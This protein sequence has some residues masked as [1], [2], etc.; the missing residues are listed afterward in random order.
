MS[1]SIQSLTGLQQNPYLMPKLC[2]ADHH[3]GQLTGGVSS[4]VAMSNEHK[5]EISLTA[6]ILFTLIS[7]GVS[8]F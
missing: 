2:S 5:G 8:S 6:Q 3:A 4:W 7:E 1:A